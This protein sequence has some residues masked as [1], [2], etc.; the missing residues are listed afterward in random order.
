MCSADKEIR[1]I[2]SFLSFFFGNRDRD[3]RK[4]QPGEQIS[5]QIVLLKVAKKE[6]SSPGRAQISWAQ[7]K[8]AKVKKKMYRYILPSMFDLNNFK[9]FKFNP[10]HSKNLSINLT[11]LAVRNILRVLKTYGISF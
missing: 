11:G 8:R 9:I 1:W 5:R 2:F 6:S 10:R 7:N 4:C 3:R